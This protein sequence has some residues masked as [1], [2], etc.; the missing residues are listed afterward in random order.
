MNEY[1][2]IHIHIE[3]SKYKMFI[4]SLFAVTAC[5]VPLFIIHTTHPSNMTMSQWIK[6]MY[7]SMDNKVN[8]PPQ[9]TVNDIF[10]RVNNLE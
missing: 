7:G 10:I 2:K 9:S 4:I 6:V 3:C 1:C 8:V 5:N